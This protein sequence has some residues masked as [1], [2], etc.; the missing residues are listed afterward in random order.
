MKTKLNDEC[1]LMNAELKNNLYLITHNSELGEAAW[2]KE[3]QR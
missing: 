3:I 1:S 2:L